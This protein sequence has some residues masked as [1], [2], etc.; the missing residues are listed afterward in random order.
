MVNIKCFLKREARSTAHK[1][2]ADL[3]RDLWAK[4]V[5][6]PKMPYYNKTIN[7]IFNV[8]IQNIFVY[9]L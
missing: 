1:P 8:F 9:S 3:A 6:Q 2:L 7:L 4:T 5:T